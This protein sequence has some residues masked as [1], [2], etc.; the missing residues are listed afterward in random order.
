MLERTSVSLEAENRRLREIVAT[1]RAENDALIMQVSAMAGGD[2][3][4]LRAELDAAN[5]RAAALR[6]AL[7]AAWREHGVEG[8]TGEEAAANAVTGRGALV[9]M[10]WN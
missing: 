9:R 2:V 3:A 1:L 6:T 5:S 8:T 10:C 7:I 4:K